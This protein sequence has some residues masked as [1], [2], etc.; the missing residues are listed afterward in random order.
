MEKTDILII[1]AGI[2]GLLCARELA[3][4]GRRVLVLEKGRGFGGRMATRR[5]EGA[6]IDHG[7]QYLTARD[8]GFS[9]RV[10][11]WVEAGVLREWFRHL[12]ED[13]NPAGYP[14]YVGVDGMTDLPKHLAVGLEVRRSER[15][16]RLSRDGG[17]WVAE[18][19]SGAVFSG[20]ILVMTLPLPQS[21]D[22][23]D[24]C[25][26]DYAGDAAAGLRAIRY[27]KGLALLAVLDGPSGLPVPGG[28]KVAEP[29]LTWIAD[30]QMKGISPEVPAVTVHADAAFAEE[31]WDS[32]DAVRA[33]L[34]L[35]AVK[36]YLHSHVVAHSCHRWG[37]TLPL[38]PW[39]AKCFV[40]ERLDLVLA[41]DAFGGP[42]IEGAAL[43]GLAAAEAV[44]EV[45]GDR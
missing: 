8:P 35:E 27:E 19:E 6:R 7:A 38:N 40:N 42:R 26:L 2:S 15:I 10:D 4:A 21:L 33:P 31:H 43:S 18:S 23:L 44:V 13:S 34:L 17:R 24:A 39:P 29:P 9:A 22:L 3:D 5:M 28:L 20:R 25:G 1:G 12:P 45:M 32:E 37:F 11:R 30:N 41:G 36:P 14:R 16:T